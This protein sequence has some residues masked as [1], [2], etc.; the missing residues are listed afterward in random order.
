MHG[1]Q[2]LLM[3]SETAKRGGFAAAARELGT[4]P[5]TIAKGV[6]RLEAQLGLRLFHRTTRQVRLSADGERLFERCQRVLAELDELQSEAAG[7]RAEPQGTLRVDMPITYGRRVVMPVLARL[8]QQHPRLRLDV[9]FQDAYVDL[10]RDGI[11]LA[12]RVGELQDSTLVARRIDQQQLVAIAAPAYLRR[13]GTPRRPDDLDAHGAIIF[14]LP[15]RGS[16]LAQRFVVD[17][18]VVERRPRDG[19]RSNDGDAMVEAAACGLGIAQVPDYMAADALAAGA[20]VEVLRRCRPPPTPIH[21][22]MPAKAHLPARVRV[23]LDA[24]AAQT[25]R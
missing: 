7:V 15:G 20:V 10:V 5:S 25:K 17:G 19:H 13:H 24:L 21:A 2:A 4:S 6:G 12:V 3:F 16:D 22:V 11:D 23:L 18:R 1:I 8:V 9:R 14:R